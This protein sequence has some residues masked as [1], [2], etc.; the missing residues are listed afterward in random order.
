MPQGHKGSR[1]QAII[2]PDS[3]PQTLWSGIHF[4][5]KIRM[6]IG[7]GPGSGR[8]WE[9]KQD[10]WPKKNKGPEEL[11]YV[12]DSNHLSGKL[13]IQNGIHITNRALKNGARKPLKKSKGIL[14]NT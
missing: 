1:D 6:H 12:S 7:E 3:H 10:N 13:L 4:G 5:Q 14:K 11:S 8:V 9:I 2:S